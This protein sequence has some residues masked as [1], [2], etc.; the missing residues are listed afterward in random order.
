MANHGRIWLL[1]ALASSLAGCSFYFDTSS[2]VGMADAGDA[3]VADAPPSDSDVEPDAND[4]THPSRPEVS[5]SPTAPRTADDLVAMIT[6]PSVDPM[7]ETVVYEYRWL[8]DTMVVATET[9]ATLPNALTS[10]GQRWTVEVTPVAGSRRGPAGTAEVTIENTPPVLVTVGLDQYHPVVGERVR[11]VSGSIQD[12]DG[13]VAGRHFQ[14]YRGATAI[15]GATG[16]QLDLSMF[17]AGDELRLESWATDS[18]EGPRVTVGPVTVLADV[19]RWRPITA[20]PIR[21]AHVGAG[22][23]AYDRPRERIVQFLNGEAW[24]F[25][26]SGT[27]LRAARLAPRGVPPL[28]TAAQIVLHDSAHDRLLV[29]DRD[30]AMQLHALDLSHRGAEVWTTLT[31]AG[32]RPPV[33]GTPYFAIWE[34][35]SRI[36]LYGGD[37]SAASPDTRLVNLDVSAVGAE[38]W[39]EL[40]LSIDNP[41]VYFGTMVAHPTLAGHALLF[42]GASLITGVPSLAVYD[43]AIG[44]GAVTFE[45]VADIPGA[46]YGPRSVVRSGRVILAGGT[47]AIF[48]ISPS[49]TLPVLEFDPGIAAFSTVAT[50]PTTLQS[51]LLLL[52]SDGTLTHVAVD[53]VERHRRIE[54]TSI[55]PV[56]AD[57]SVIAT[58]FGSPDTEA[59]SMS[60]AMLRALEAPD[61]EWALR[62]FDPVAHTWTHVATEPDIVLGSA[63]P[64]RIG[65]RT[66]SATHEYTGAGIVLFGGREPSSS[67]LVPSDVWELQSDAHWIERRVASGPLPPVRSGAASA[68]IGCGGAA[69]NYVISGGRRSDGSLL[70][71]TWVMTCA[72]HR[73]CSWREAATTGARPAPHAN[74]SLA[75]TRVHFGV[76]LGRPGSSLISRLDVCASDTAEWSIMTNTGAAPASLA[77]QVMTYAPSAPTADRLMVLGGDGTVDAVYF[78]TLIDDGTLDWL[79]VPVD[80]MDSPPPSA[81]PVAV[82]DSS[83]NRLLVLEAQTWE[84]RVR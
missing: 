8:R 45:R 35:D 69:P 46:R 52:E 38:R 5:L 44:T 28:S 20:P 70:D 13:D 75:V 37:S 54:M 4:P 3:H 47:D 31:A 82:W 14:W 10:R 43:V 57:V 67:V 53:G 36:W 72:G 29:I 63:P 66:Q 22:N 77:L 65:F 56:S 40:P 27:D 7:S 50:M 15:A 59:A 64:V 42:G 24:E 41:N 25:A 19:T 61:G 84:L 79:S 49:E 26:A 58:D 80:T 60:G 51:T 39:T 33:E 17:T 74:G 12:A 48:F 30:N 34:Q 21:G 6:T 71:D 68:S 1:A 73:E 81:A 32:D 16:S 76:L 55:D 9:T 11:A 18:N 2:Y 62:V 23:I 83:L 78:V